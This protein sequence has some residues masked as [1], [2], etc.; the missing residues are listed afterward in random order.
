M[1][2]QKRVWY[3]SFVILLV[4][5]LFSARVLYWQMIRGFQMQPVAL[6]P[7]SA[8]AAYAQQESAGG[9]PIPNEQG[10]FQNLD[11]LPQ[12]VLQRTIALLQ[13][14]TR[15]SIVDRSG[16]VLALDQ[17]DAA[18][19][20]T[21]VYSDPSLV[22]VTGYT[23]ALRTGLTGLE[24]SY[25]DTL[26]GVNRLDSQ[27][28]MSLHEP[29]QGSDLILTIDDSLQQKAA[30]ALGN[31]AGSI[32][33]LDGH[34][35][36]VLAL[37]SYPYFD[38]NHILDEGYAA[39]LINSCDGSPSC[40]APFL[41]RAMQAGYTPG[42]TFKTVTLIAALDTGQVT[43]ETMFDFGAPVQGPNGIYYVYRVDG[44]EIID[45]NHKQDRLSLPMAYAYS[46]NA[47]F[48]KLGDQM[49][50][51]TFINYARK[52]G[53]SPLP[54]QGFPFE[55]EYN[56]SH[57]ANDVDELRS[58]NLLRAA[59]A[60]GQ[61]EIETT[62]MN[63]AMVFLSALNNGSLPL[64]YFVQGVRSPG[65]QMQTNLPN[66]RVL[67]NLYK[68][69][70]AQQVRGMM[71]TAVQEG[72]GYRAQLPGITVGGKTGTAQLGGSQEPHAWFAG[73]ADNGKQSVVIVTVL[74]N[75]GSGS[76]EPAAIFAQ[77]APS[78]LDI[79][80]S[81]SGDANSSPIAQLVPTVESTGQPPAATPTSEAA[82]LE[83]TAVEP[84]AQ[85]AATSTPSDVNEPLPI[86]TLSS[87]PSPDILRDP[88]RPQFYADQP[89]CPVGPDPPMGSG[90]FIW[91]SQ[92]Q[93][94]SGAAFTESHP[95]IDLNA[96]MDSPVYAADDGV[97]VFAGVTNVGYGRVILIDHRNG[98]QSLYGHLDQISVR[99]GESVSKGKIIGLSGNTGNSSGPHLHFEVRVPDGFINPLKVLPSP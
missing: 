3:L 22:F 63:I 16:T 1:T 24:R 4:L 8:A 84:T 87:L 73:F 25:N 53:F 89:S 30:A 39:S 10:A 80:T 60:I 72:S 27:L 76:Q 42:S 11:A 71:V 41:D 75:G 9:P 28:A 18:G 91:P 12:P 29:V 50:P 98:Y 26:L 52:L 48:A 61:G 23:S 47:A 68:A 78:A 58:N 97:V 88:S 46:A 31:R 70:T 56:Q 64:P 82:A 90:K 37:A 17:V 7:L 6:D 86:V 67:R 95:G 59:T 51:D 13:T 21:R 14:I 5:T 99:C 57:L 96:P 15:G 45:P 69:K 43:P 33:I 35:G 49:L 92:Y 2:F 34:T 65:G 32:L 93:N 40:T 54:G 74:E 66:R 83:P 94:I 20:R 85:P 62:P 81:V 44:G 38:P 77:L 79:A 55:I 36:A 19:N